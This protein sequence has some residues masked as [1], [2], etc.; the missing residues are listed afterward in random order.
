[1]DAGQ[2]FIIMTRIEPM[3]SN[4]AFTALLTLVILSAACKPAE[5]PKPEP[6]LILPSGGQQQAREDEATHTVALVIKALANPFFMAIE[7]GAR[8]AEKELGVRLLVRS[9]GD[10]TAI[11]QQIAIVEQL[12]RDKVD[13]IVIIPGNSTEMVPVV[14]KAQDAGIAIVNIDN[15]LDPATAREWGLSVPWVSVDNAR[16]GYLSAQYL[17]SKLT[18][19]TPVV[20]VTGDTTSFAGQERVRG[21]QQAFKENPNA[22]LQE[23]ELAYWTIEEAYKAA[24]RLFERHP[25]V[26]AIFSVNDLM[27]LG[28]QRYLEERG[29]SDVLF[30][31]YDNIEEARVAIR[32]GKLLA[33][34]DQQAEEQGYL[35]VKYAVRALAGEKL[36]PETLVDVKLVTAESLQQQ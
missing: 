28:I 16:G 22:L 2:C 20:I 23:T 21:A 30:A 1:L 3:R 6:P 12:I 14:K 33:T 17:A 25:E 13:A 5:E 9:H 19:P 7:K 24:P 26:G 11:E 18:R 34:I 29:R 10:E 27:A 31:G 15:R 32:Q 35:G 36:P 8:R 4:S